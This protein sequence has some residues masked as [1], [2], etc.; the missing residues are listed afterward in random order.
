MYELFDEMMD[1]GYPQCTEAKVL[2]EFICVQ[3][4]HKFVQGEIPTIPDALTQSVSWR[5]KGI[6]HSKNEIFLDVV[7]KLT[8]LVASNGTVLRSEVVGA[9]K[10]KSFLSGIP[11][12]KLGLNDKI[13]MDARTRSGAA[14]SKVAKSVD[15]EDIRFHQCVS[16]ARYVT[17]VDV[18]FVV[19]CCHLYTLLLLH[20]FQLNVNYQTF[21]KLSLSIQLFNSIYFNS[22]QQLLSIISFQ[23]SH[24]S[25]LPCNLFDQIR[26]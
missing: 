25:S 10:M 7:E 3:E 17:I 1:F 2:Q 16:L 8:L 19:S 26:K 11:E 6:V 13:L 22:I 23:S 20:F 21:F 18:Q 15:M 12:L 5:K 24:I 9:L 14:A 4:R